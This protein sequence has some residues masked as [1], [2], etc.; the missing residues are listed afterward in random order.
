M[1]YVTVRDLRVRPGDVWKKLR[2]QGEM[3]L[4]SNGRPMAIIAHVEEDDV[5]ATLAAAQTG[6]RPGRSG[7]Y[8]PFG[9]SA[10]T[11]PHYGRRH[12][13]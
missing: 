4:T 8:A 10:G 1:G 13:G 9:G 11:G 3:I 2:Q 7:S 5:E 6:S 12:R